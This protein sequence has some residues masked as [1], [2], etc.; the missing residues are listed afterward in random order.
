MTAPMFHYR[1][2]GDDDDLEDD[3]EAPVLLGT[4]LREYELDAR[5]ARMRARDGAALLERQ[6]RSQLAS[7]SRQTLAA[8]R[9]GRRGPSPAWELLG[10]IE[11][12][13]Q[14]GGAERVW[15]VVADHPQGGEW[16]SKYRKKC[17]RRDCRTCGGPT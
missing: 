6:I 1:Q 2:P 9:A 14:H 10:R 8:A 16:R 13:R 15:H 11:I 4:L 7:L 12:E 17:T 5:E 3:D